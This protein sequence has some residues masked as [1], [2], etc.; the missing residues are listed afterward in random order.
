MNDASFFQSFIFWQI[1]CAQYHHADMRMGAAVHYVGYLKEGHARL[2]GEKTTLTLQAGDYFYIP[3]FCRYQSYWYGAPVICFDS[4][5]FQCYPENRHLTYP[6]QIIP[7]NDEI[8]ALHAPLMDNKSSSCENIGR[9]L[10]LFSACLR[11]MTAQPLS[12][13]HTAVDRA[14]RAMTEQPG[15]SAPELAALCGISESS[16]YNAF[17]EVLGLT[18]VAMK[19]KLLAEKAVDLLCTTDASVESISAQLGFSSTSYFRKILAQ[20]TGKTPREIRKN[21]GI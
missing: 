19:H 3:R 13:R 5:G 21:A 15:L 7:A 8:R 1:T 16:L 20:Q 9:F 11:Q 6:L 12:P 18:P 10:L 14:V 4:F 17:Q 2:E